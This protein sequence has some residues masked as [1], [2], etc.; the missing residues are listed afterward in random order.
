MRLLFLVLL[1]SCVTN[2]ET[3]EREPDWPRIADGFELAASR[4]RDPALHDAAAPLENSEDIIKSLEETAKA[5]DAVSTAI[6]AFIAAGGEEG[7]T[8]EILA[9]VKGLTTLASGLTALTD[10]ESTKAKIGF[11]V[12]AI[13]S[14]VDFAALYLPEDEELDAALSVLDDSLPEAT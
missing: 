7:S 9:A 12:F 6:D 3:G 14:A 4:L 5:C 11:A 10:D 1:I 2:P 13:N 8:Q